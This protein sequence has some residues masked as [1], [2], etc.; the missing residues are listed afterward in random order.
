MVTVLRSR[1]W[2][3]IG[4]TIGVAVLAFLFSSS[5]PDRYETHA[6]V[7]TTN[8]D[9]TVSPELRD[10]TGINR[11]MAT[12]SY[13]VLSPTVEAAV[14]EALGDDFDQI[15]SLDVEPIALT[16][17]LRITVS[18]NSPEIAAAGADAYA[19]SY[20]RLRRDQLMKTT[21]EL[22]ADLDVTL[23]E[24]ETRLVEVAQELESID[25]PVLA[26]PLVV[27]QTTLTSARNEYLTQ[28]FQLNQALQMHAGSISQSRQAI[29]PT[30]PYAPTPAS[31]ALVAGLIVLILTVGISFILDQLDNRI[32]ASDDIAR[33]AADLPVLG[34]IP[35]TRHKR[36]TPA[37]FQKVDRE[38]VKGNSTAAEAYRVLATSLRFSSLGKEKRT[39][40]VTSSNSGEGKTTVTA[41]L[42][43]MLAASGLRVVLVSADL[44]RPMLGQLLGIDDLADGLTS[45]M[46]GDSDLSTCFVPVALPS[47][48][49]L[50]VLPSGP[51][52][53]EPAVLLG[54]DAFGEML[55]EI[56]EAGADFILIDCAPVLPVSDPLAASRHVDGVLLLA[57]ADRTKQASFRSAVERLR[58]VN[59]EI[60]GV[61]LNGVGGKGSP[62][63]YQYY[64]DDPYHARPSEPV[65]P[66]AAP[67]PPPSPEGP[68]RSAPDSV[69]R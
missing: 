44:R 69:R 39:I 45:A 3:I 63:G 13:Y 30:S 2:L 55:D 25:N 40:L 27:E 9:I 66:P 33:I 18:S 11:R 5:K 57:L 62:Y 52:P 58:K 48:K 4:A 21:R 43:A 65:A 54:S 47:G 7:A 50:Y 35:M 42:A 8:S 60:I 46:L 67:A 22:I 6:D 28:R 1:A 38:L 17:V 19:E 26:P 31:D 16:E 61:V 23:E 29:V 53:H 32:K 51:L 56:K 37:R 68:A 49:N 15:T 12:E 34:T 59:A 10:N 41:N 14:E 24:N 64:G 36:F 20:V